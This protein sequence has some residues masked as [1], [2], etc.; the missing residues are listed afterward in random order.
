MRTARGFDAKDDKPALPPPPLKL[1]WQWWDLLVA[2]QL[3]QTHGPGA[4]TRL[5]DSNLLEPIEAAIQQFPHE[6]VAESARELIKQ[7]RG[8]RVSF[9]WP[10]SEARQQF[11]RAQMQAAISREAA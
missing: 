5:Y 1:S 4:V 3:Y 6:D 2:S 9:T 10:M 7:V 8:R 11:E